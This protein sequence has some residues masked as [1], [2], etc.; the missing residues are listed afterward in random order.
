MWTL[1][2]IKK[3]AQHQGYQLQVIGIPKT[4]DND[5]AK[6]DHAPGFGSAA[7]YI[8]HAVRDISKDLEAMQSFEQVRIIET[9]G[10]N[11]GW[12][13]APSGLLRENDNDGPHKIYLPENQL[14]VEEFLKNIS[15]V[16]QENG[17]A[18]IVISEGTGL[19][20]GSLLAL[21]N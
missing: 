5:I 21:G 15:G 8:A 18:T 9:M 2:K 17:Y 6:T 14:N 4:V 13:A 11:V 7:R 20:G 16:V 19:N 1:N 10:R 12:L 3:A